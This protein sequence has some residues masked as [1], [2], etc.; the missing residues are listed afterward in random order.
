[1][2]TTSTKV[3]PDITNFAL[4]SD[5]VGDRKLIGKFGGAWCH[6]YEITAINRETQTATLTPVPFGTAVRVPFTRRS[7]RLAMFPS[8][9]PPFRYYTDDEYEYRIERCSDGSGGTFT[10][11]G[12]A[13]HGRAA[14]V[15]GVSGKRMWKLADRPVVP[16]KIVI[17]DGCDPPCVD[18]GS[19]I[20]HKQAM[21]AS[22]PWRFAAQIYLDSE[23]DDYDV[24]A[25][26]LL[27]SELLA[28]CERCDTDA[29]HAKRRAGEIS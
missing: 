11:P 5:Q 19:R 13:P 29:V 1:M 3:L 28:E 10:V 8:E 24:A 14:L 27:G 7:R 26:R 9:L 20:V 22:N 6:D 2:A 16:A 21:P 23:V 4:T 17:V 12:A 15:L 18:D 25:K